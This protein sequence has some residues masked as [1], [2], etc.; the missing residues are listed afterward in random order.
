MKL[1]R[2]WLGLV[3]M[4]WITVTVMAAPA[5]APESQGPISD[6]LRLREKLPKTAPPT[7]RRVV[8]GDDNTLEVERVRYNYVAEAI[9]RKVQQDGK[10]IEVSEYVVRTVPV[11]YRERIAVKNCTFYTVT[12]DG[13]LETLET[14]KA[15]AQL[16]KPAIVLT[17]DSAE[18][19]P[20][21]L[22]VVKSGTLYLVLP[23]A[24]TS[25]AYTPGPESVKGE[26]FEKKKE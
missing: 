5:P 12:K 20:R 19:D 4:A 26:P 9:L 21:H 2:L 23:V 22:E 16:K 17:G 3:L 25:A 13:K 11:V 15:T 14:K 18:V 6:A 1:C 8:L 24:A 7:S 10:E